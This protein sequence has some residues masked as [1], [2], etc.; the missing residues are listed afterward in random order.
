MTEDFVYV[1]LIG[2]EWEDM[3][4][5]LSKEDAIAASKKYPDCRVEIFGKKNGADVG[6]VPTYSYYENGEYFKSE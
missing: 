4:V 6:Y 5:Y 3:T 1:L 2:S